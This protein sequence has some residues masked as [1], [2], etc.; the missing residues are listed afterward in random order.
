[1]SD[2]RAGDPPRATLRIALARFADSALALARTR[3]ELASVE[4][5][6]ERAR[7]TRSA[8]L[9]AGAVAMFAFAVFGVAAWIVVYFWDTHRL[10][11]I[12]LVTLAFLVA[13]ALM[14]WRNSAIWRDASPPFSQTLA[15]L[16]K[17][18]AWLRGQS[19]IETPES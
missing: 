18:R 11:A 7:W 17:D 5:A 15:E 13:G 14:L 6:E 3:A 12:A 1:M 4:L 9:V 8:M 10:T 19:G 2:D 16:D